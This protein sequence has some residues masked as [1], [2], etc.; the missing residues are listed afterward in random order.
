MYFIETNGPYLPAHPKRTLPRN[1]KLEAVA[2]HHIDTDAAERDDADADNDSG[3][4][5]M[6]LD[7]AKLA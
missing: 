6:D 1:A 7:K 5:A 4:D 2:S 3:L